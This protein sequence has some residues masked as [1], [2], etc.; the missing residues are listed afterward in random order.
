MYDTINKLSSLHDDVEVLWSTLEALAVALSDKDA[1]AELFQPAVRGAA[2]RAF[3][4]K[5][6]LSDILEEMDKK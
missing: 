1:P 2:N 4:I 3:E 5:G 6:K